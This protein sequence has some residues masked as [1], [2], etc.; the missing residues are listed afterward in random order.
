MPIIKRIERVYNSLKDCKLTDQSI[1]RITAKLRPDLENIGQFYGCSPDEALFLSLIFG[2]KVVNSTVYYNDMVN[3]LDCNPFFVVSHENLFKSLQKKRL[4]TKEDNWGRNSISLNLTRE[5]YN[6]AATNKPLLQS[7]K[8]VEDVYT[9]LQRTDNLINERR[10]EVISTQELLEEIRQILQN[11]RGASTVQRIERLQLSLRE[12]AMLLFLCYQ[13]A[14]GEDFVDLNDMMNSIFDTVSDKVS[15]KRELINGEAGLVKQELVAFENDFFLMGRTL[16]LTDKAI[17]ELFGD[18]ETF[19]EVKRPFR[20]IHT[21][22]LEAK[23]LQ[24][25]NLF[26]NKTEE[27]QVS[28]LHTLLGGDQL[29]HV[30]Q[31][32]EQAGLGKGVVVLLYGDPGTGKT[33]TVYS[34]A[35]RTQRNVLL[36]DIA[37]IKDKYVGESEKHLKMLFE[38]YRKAVSHFER[39]PILLFNESDAL[40]SKRIELTSSVDQ[41]NN[42]MQ[43]IL[44]QELESFEGILFATSNLNVNLDKAFERRFPYKIHFGKPDTATRGKIWA[45]KLPDLDS[46]AV[47]RLA[48]AFELTG[49]QIDNIIRKYLLHNILNDSSPDLTQIEQMCAEETLYNGG[50]RIGF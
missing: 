2:L 50:S 21:R 49:G 34:I 25:K 3:Y 40:I 18:A 13:F 5:A 37:N 31:K 22:L 12:T 20:P 28:L 16:R 45:S 42:S 48:Q 1:S 8:E 9:L 26:L 7:E 43:N 47:T 10:K 11:E 29:T 14:N 38:E 33:E 4:I 35:S 30:Q 41:M 6:A 19:P 17:T 27:K 36:V 39:T 15:S 46:S 23:S 24:T 44:L 32:F